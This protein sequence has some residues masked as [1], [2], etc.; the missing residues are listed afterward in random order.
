MIG[1]MAVM[2]AAVTTTSA[3][4]PDG[5]SADSTVTA[6]Y[7]L[8]SVPPGGT[9]NWNRIDGLFVDQGI[10]VTMMPRDGKTLMAKTDLPTLRSQT[11]AAYGRSGFMEREY[12]REVRTFGDIASIYSSF[13]I[14]LPQNAE[15]PLARGLHH[16]QL[17]KAQGCWRIVS[18]ISQTEGATWQLPAAFAPD[19]GSQQ[20]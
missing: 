16:F 10:F 9:W 7:D 3:A 18:N 5:R 13:Y 14:A 8:I 15:S 2:A 4:C 20:K 17:I 11:Q 6:L 12:K 1:F 19:T